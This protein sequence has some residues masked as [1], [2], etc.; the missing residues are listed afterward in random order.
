[1]KFERMDGRTQETKGGFME[2]LG[3][4]GFMFGMVGIVA[5]VQ[6]RQITKTLKEKGSWIRITKKNR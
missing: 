6:V 3:M 1:M 4:T 5:S 2:A